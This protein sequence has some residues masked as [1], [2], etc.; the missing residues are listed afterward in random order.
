MIEK[1][2]IKQLVESYLAGSDNYLVDVIIAPGNIITL[3]I[4][5]DNGVDIDFCATLSKHVES[6]LDRDTVDFELTVTSTGLTNPLK[7]PRQYRK[8]IGEDVEILT[9]NGIKHHAILIAA[10]EDGFVAEITKLERPE[11][12]KRK[13]EIKEELSFKYDEVKYTKYKIRF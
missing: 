11:G 1:K 12:A 13:I 5:N 2:E 9:K 8:F 6:Q 3:E 7:T 4:D 10:E